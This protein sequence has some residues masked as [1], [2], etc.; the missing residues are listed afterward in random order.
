MSAGSGGAGRSNATGSCVATHA[1][2]RPALPA[3]LVKGGRVLCPRWRPCL[4]A[5]VCKPRPSACCPAQ[6]AQGTPTP[7][8]S[9]YTHTHTHHPPTANPL[10]AARPRRFWTR[11]AWPSTRWTRCWLAWKRSTRPPVTAAL[12]RCGGARA[13]GGA[14]RPPAGHTAALPCCPAPR[15]ACPRRAVPHRCVSA[16]YGPCW[17]GRRG[18]QVGHRGGRRAGLGGPGV[19][20]GG[21]TPVGACIAHCWLPHPALS[22]LA[23]VQDEAAVKA[24]EALPQCRNDGEPT[25]HAQPAAGAASGQAGRGPGM[26]SLPCPVRLV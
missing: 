7:P 22:A 8:H 23:P 4:Q 1:Q 13:V 6:P 12:R 20:S 24:L 11:A 25:R 2:R 14:G 10:P 18:A 15:R 17:C 5:P 19:Q 26:P 3:A 9:N 16:L 21:T